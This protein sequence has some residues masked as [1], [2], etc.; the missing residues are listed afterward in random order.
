[1]SDND[2]LLLDIAKQ[3]AVS[4]WRALLTPAMWDDIAHALETMPE[5]EAVA[6]ANTI[7]RNAAWYWH[8]G[9]DGK[10]PPTLDH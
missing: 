5:D 8:K 9:A 3:N 4:G 7:I 6:Y 10:K 2:D 1:M